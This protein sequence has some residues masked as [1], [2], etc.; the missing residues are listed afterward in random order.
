MHSV[1]LSKIIWCYWCDPW[2]TH[3]LYI[4][5]L[6]PGIRALKSRSHCSATFVSI[7]TNVYVYIYASSVSIRFYFLEQLL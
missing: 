3:S 6:I 5:H 1:F 7:E 4:Y 2:W